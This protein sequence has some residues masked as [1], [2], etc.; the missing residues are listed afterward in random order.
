MNGQEALYVHRLRAAAQLPL[1]RHQ[2]ELA[3]EAGLRVLLALGI[4]LVEC[5]CISEFLN[6]KSRMSIEN[7]SCPVFRSK[8]AATR[9]FSASISS[10]GA[11]EN[12]VACPV[13][14]V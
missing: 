12:K 6:W 7:A 2:H 3:R 9:E 13:A 11:D 10:G 14:V 4:V 8:M 5:S 1:G